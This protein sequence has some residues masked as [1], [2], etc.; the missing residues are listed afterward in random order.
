MVPAIVMRIDEEACRSDA[1]FQVS[2]PI[3]DLKRADAGRQCFI[4][5]SYPDK[6]VGREHPDL[7]LSMLVSQ[8]LGKR[9]RFTLPSHQQCALTELRQHRPQVE[10]DV[11][12]LFERRVTFWQ[13]LQDIERLF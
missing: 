13:S 6:Q 3:G 2:E 5:P 7:A 10:A 8:P 9:H 1:E 12:A 11:T 4:E